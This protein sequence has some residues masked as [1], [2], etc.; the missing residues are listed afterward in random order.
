MRAI[1]GFSETLPVAC[2]LRL[3]PPLLVRPGELRLGRLAGMRSRRLASS[4]A[5]TGVANEDEGTAHLHGRLR[6]E[7]RTTPP[8]IIKAGITFP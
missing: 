6:S 5:D 1:D 3:A 2:A 8:T 4:M 7:L